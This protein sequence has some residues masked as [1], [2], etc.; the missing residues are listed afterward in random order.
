[1]SLTIEAPS[2]T[3]A[4][5]ASLPNTGAPDSPLPLLLAALGVGLIATSL[6]ARR[7]KV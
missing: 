7:R 4:P 6:L 1:V 5:P 3:A 2:P